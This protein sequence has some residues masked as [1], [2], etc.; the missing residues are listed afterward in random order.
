MRDDIACLSFGE[1]LPQVSGTTPLCVV[2][3]YVAR[4]GVT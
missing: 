3:L 1:C 2:L 4:S